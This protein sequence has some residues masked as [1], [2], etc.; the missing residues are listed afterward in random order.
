MD[1]PQYQIRFTAF[2][3]IPELTLSDENIDFQKVCVGTRKTI[4]LRLENNKEVACDWWYYFKPDISAPKDAGE[5]F[6]VSPQQGILQPGQKQTVDVMFFP[7]NDKAF[8]QKL[9]FRCKENTK[10][11]VV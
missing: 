1:G 2:L 6:Q 8:Q 11:F 10:Q 4:K 9:T 3:T 7:N 5:R